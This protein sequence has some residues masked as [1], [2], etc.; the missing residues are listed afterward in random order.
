MTGDRKEATSRSS[1]QVVDV[2]RRQLHHALRVGGALS[3][4]GRTSF[5]R[6]LEAGDPDAPAIV[7]PGERSISYGTLTD[8]VDSLASGLRALG[9]LPGDRVAFVLPNGPE[10]IEVL[11]AVGSLG[12]AAA[13][14]NPALT[15]SELSFYLADISPQHVLVPSGL[16]AEARE[17]AQAGAQLIDVETGLGRPTLRGNGKVATVEVG[18]YEASPEDVALLLH[19]SGTTSRPKQVPLLHRNLTASASH[20]A[21]HYDLGRD[22]VSYCVMPLFHVHGLVASAFA[23]LISGGTVV[24]PRRVGPRTFWEDLLVHGA[25]WFSVVPTFLHML[26]NGRPVDLRTRRPRLRFVRTCSAPLRTELHAQAEVE[27]GVPVI[28]AYGMTEASHQIS[29]NPLPPAER[30]PGSVGVPTGTELRVVDDLGRDVSTETPGEIVIR[31]PGVM[32]GYSSS[33][34]TADSF[35]D[36]WFRTGDIGRMSGDYLVLEGRIKE[37]II[38][39]GENV[40]PYEVENVILGHPAVTDALCFGLPDEKYGEEVAVAVCLRA[41]LDERELI[42]YCREHLAPFKIP[43]IVRIVQAIPRTATGK[44]QRKALAA[45]VAAELCT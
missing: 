44:P 34:A 25:T 35:V 9:V 37:L 43:K 26:L 10:A 19:T 1:R 12:A 6:L 27:L 15:G 24:V 30:L 11:L 3:A 20:I 40:S 45:S 21:D 13:P 38:R 28:Q 32:P 36:G 33:A 16:N 39:G 41:D 5:G 29:S 7:C 4:V 23:T 17:A 31:G 14:L 8:E 22:D 18:A 42:G 2:T